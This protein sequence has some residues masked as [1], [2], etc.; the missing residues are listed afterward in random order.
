MFLFYWEGTPHACVLMSCK[1]FCISRGYSKSFI[2]MNWKV[3]QNFGSYHIIRW[4]LGV[5][6]KQANLNYIGRFGL[7]WPSKK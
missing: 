6:T 1:L 2:M 4:Y 7:F 5:D 3:G